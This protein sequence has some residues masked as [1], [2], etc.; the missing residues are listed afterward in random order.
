MG[1]E[2]L[3]GNNEPSGAP[4][5]DQRSA[6]RVISTGND[7]RSGNKRAPRSRQNWNAMTEPRSVYTE[8][9]IESARGRHA[10]RV[11]AWARSQTAAGQCRCGAPIAVGSTSR[12]L[13][14]LERCRRDQR[15][16][17]G[18]PVRGRA[19]RRRRGRRIIGSL[20]ERRRA[21]ERDEA[22][23]QRERVRAVERRELHQSVFVVMRRAGS[24][25]AVDPATKQYVW[26]RVYR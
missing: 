7:E 25:L 1:L 20:S 21:L 8:G 18:D 12:C 16:R 17:R 3:E 10:A 4:G 9:T 6:A 23:A 22:R 14:C 26:T 13:G 5:A 2:T 19:G 15:R 11:R 24:V